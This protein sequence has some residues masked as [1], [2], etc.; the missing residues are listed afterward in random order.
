VRSCEPARDPNA[1]RDSSNQSIGMGRQGS[2][3]S[4]GL[5]A[6]EASIRMSARPSGLNDQSASDRPSI[7][8]GTYRSVARF[9]ITVL[10]AA[11]I[12]VAANSA[13][14]SHGDKAVKLVRT[15]APS[16][17]WSLSEWQ[18]RG[19]EAK[20]V[21]TTWASSLDWLFP[22]STKS[23]RNVDIATKQRRS[24]AVPAHNGAPQ[25]SAPL[26]QKPASAA[27]TISREL[28]QQL[29]AMARD[30][31]SMRHKVEQLD[32]TQEQMTHNIA[33]LQA[34][35]R[36]I[37]Q[38]MSSPPLSSAAPLPQRKN[39]PSV[40]P[41]QPPA[42][43]Q[44][45]PQAI[46]PQVASGD[47][48]DENAQLSPRLQRQVVDYPRKEAPGTVIIDTPN[49]FLYYVL[50]NGK[51]IRYGI[52]VGREGFT[53]SGVKSIVRKA[54]WP[55]WYP[56]PEMIARQPYL[57]RMIAGGPGNPLGARAM[58]IDG[59][60]FRIHGTNDPSSIGKFMS[61][62]CIRMTNDNAIDLYNRTSVGA[63]VIVLPM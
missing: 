3:P 19:A 39:T 31:T 49:T 34:A 12:G 63:K 6:M 23:P 56:P 41:P 62:G 30:L 61:S 53:W 29:E 35:D 13:W 46:E 60:E 1:I 14:Q 50:G 55:D 16:L 4:P 32:A 51:A 21:I 54:E 36:N 24:A 5:R 33:S 26:A 9:F 47:E 58:Y 42:Q 43:T 40:A 2:E 59:S 17:G 38:K 7:G 11:F 18:S 48:Q 22:V 28:A 57:P 37:R 27:A 10:I 8:G 44:I 20:R 45:A 25:Q 15:Y 52:G